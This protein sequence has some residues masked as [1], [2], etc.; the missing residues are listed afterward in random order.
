MY[1]PCETVTRYVLPAFRSFVAIELVEKYSYTQ[2]EAAKRLGTTQA[3]ISQY[4]HFKRGYRGTNQFKKALPRIR[5]SAIETARRMA[6]EN[7]TPDE[8]MGAFCSLCRKL[9]PSIC[10][11]GL[12]PVN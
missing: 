3:A 12:S 11:E 5:E 10:L 4:L 9:H 6:L 2:V 8:A 7:I 1:P